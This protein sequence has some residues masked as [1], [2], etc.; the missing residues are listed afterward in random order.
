MHAITDELIFY[1]AITNGSTAQWS[2][3]RKLAGN[4]AKCLELGCFG[5]QGL[6]A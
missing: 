3:N 1:C 5:S 2:E 6:W 4:D